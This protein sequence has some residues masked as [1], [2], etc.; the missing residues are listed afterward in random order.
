MTRSSDLI[1][2]A[3]FVLLGEASHGTHEFYRERAADHEAADRGE[4]LHGRRGRGRLARRLPRQ[5]L[6]ARRER[7]RRRRRSARR[8]PALPDLDV[9][10]HRRGRVRRVAAR[11]QRRASAERAEGR[12]LRPR[13]LQ[14]ARLDGGRAALSR[15]GRPRGGEAGPRALRLLRPFRRGHP[16]LRLRRPAPA[17]PSRARRRSSA[18]SSSCNAAPWSTRDATVAW[19]RT[20]SST[21]SRTPAW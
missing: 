17:S 4:G 1:G 3:R 11:A 7:R 15:E 8:L 12:L 5:P 2:D 19:P 18:S 14:P 20:S 6:R 16:G 9:A 13:S 21:P 10:Q